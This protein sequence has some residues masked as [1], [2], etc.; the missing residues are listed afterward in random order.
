MESSF[1]LEELPDVLTVEETATV[2]RLSRG[3]TYEAVRQGQ[4]PSLRLGRRLLIPKAGLVALLRPQ[5]AAPED[6]L[7]RV[8]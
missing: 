4:I 1:R 7:A 6:D 8:F 3:A 2:L 5:P